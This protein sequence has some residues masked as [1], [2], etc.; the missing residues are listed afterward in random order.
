MAVAASRQSLRLLN[1]APA[2]KLINNCRQRPI[3]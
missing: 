3:L 1:P 2:A